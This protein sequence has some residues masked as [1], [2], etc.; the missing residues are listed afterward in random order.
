MKGLKKDSTIF[1][2][3][4]TLRDLYLTI[5]DWRI[6]KHLRRAER[7]LRKDSYT[8]STDT[9]RRRTQLDRLRAYWQRGEFPRNTSRKE[10]TP[11]FKGEDAGTLCA[12]GFLMAKDGRE[13]LADAIAA[14]DNHVWLE[15]VQDGP[16][17]DW[18]ENSGLTMQ[19]A[20]RIQPTYGGSTHL[21]TTC[22]PL[23]CEALTY[24]LFILGAL[25]FAALEWAAYR[26]ASD[27]FPAN[28]LKRRLSL[29]HLSAGNVLLVFIAA[30]IFKALFP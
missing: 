9:D 15:N 6:Q 23:G 13:D 26:F 25:G 16:V 1:S 29:I 10:R 21:A 27:F 22:Q 17:K 5:E 28:A 11:C 20:A 19:E 12:V 24:V 3:T 18:I 8:E 7:E 30:V 2:V 4:D 14:E